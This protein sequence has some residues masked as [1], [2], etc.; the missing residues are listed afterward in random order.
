MREGTRDIADERKTPATLLM[1]GKL[2]TFR[3]DQLDHVWDWLRA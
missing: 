1:N 2:A 3:R